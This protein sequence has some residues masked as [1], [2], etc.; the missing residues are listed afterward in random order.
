M[1]RSILASILLLSA[2]GIKI[3][4]D[5]GETVKLPPNEEAPVTASPEAFYYGDIA[6]GPA[7]RQKFDVIHFP[8]AS[9]PT[10]APVYIHGGGFSGG[11]KEELWEGKR[12]YAQ[13]ILTES[14][15]VFTCGYRV[16]ED[17]DLEGVIKPMGDSALCL[18]T[19]RHNAEVFNIDPARIVVAGTSA[20]AG[21]SLW[22]G[23]HDDMADGSEGVRG[24]STRVN[25]VVMWETQATYDL[26]RWNDVFLT[27]YGL[28]LF[29]TAESFGLA[30]AL[31]S[32]YGIS[33]NEEL[34]TEP[35]VAYRADVDM[36]ALMD[37]DDA[38]IW[39][40]NSVEKNSFPFSV[41]A[42]YHHPRHALAIVEQANEVGL[43]VEARIP[44]LDDEAPPRTPLESFD[45][46]FE[47][48]GIT[49]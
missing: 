9:E 43:R 29:E 44:T 24:Q 33:S 10:P 30:Q 13:A 34:E 41:G 45:F 28:E 15:A 37:A 2:C 1:N 12:D 35:I 47:M 48:M 46:T 26:V 8:W 21:T 32:F 18:Q 36:L 11:A 3:E 7:E 20:G 25:G 6:Y 22:L 17:V 39:V 14:A 23:T 27:Y 38:P 5:G 40:E 16:L 31:W 42:L 4:I 49:E 19:I